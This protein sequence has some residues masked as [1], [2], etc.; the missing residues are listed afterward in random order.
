MLGAVHTLN[1][2]GTFVEIIAP[3]ATVFD[4]DLSGCHCI[5]NDQ[6]N[7][8]RFNHTLRLNGCTQLTSVAGLASVHTLSLV[9]CTGLTDVSM[10]KHVHT[11][12]LTGCIHLEHMGSG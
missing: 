9:N 4:L 5:S 6:V 2:A 12:D 11:L 7:Q 8:L 10:L 1:L 3:L